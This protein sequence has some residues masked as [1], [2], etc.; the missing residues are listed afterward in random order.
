MLKSV[1]KTSHIPETIATTKWI[2]KQGV[3]SWSGI[4]RTVA[5]MNQR[6]TTA[7]QL[8]WRQSKA[9]EVNRIQ[10]WTVGKPSSPKTDR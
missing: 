2:I 8:D 1:Y 9:N 4:G 3:R 10:N 5:F 7:L 6:V